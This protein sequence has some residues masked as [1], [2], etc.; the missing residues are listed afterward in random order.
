MTNLPRDHKNV[1]CKIKR[2][3]SIFSAKGD[4]I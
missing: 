4:W 3:T 2:S 1:L